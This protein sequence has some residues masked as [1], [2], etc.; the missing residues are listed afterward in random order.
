MRIRYW[1]ENG[2]RVKT[3]YATKRSYHGG[4]AI[5]SGWTWNLSARC[6]DTPIRGIF[7]VTSV[8][9]SRRSAAMVLQTIFKA[10]PIPENAKVFIGV[11][12]VC[13][14]SYLPIYMRGA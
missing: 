13:S 10:L 1:S 4:G 7:L 8:F 3:R 2:H 5:L 11:V 9:V 14:A 12:L 6:R